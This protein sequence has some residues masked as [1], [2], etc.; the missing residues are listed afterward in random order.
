MSLKR[1]FA[2]EWLKLRRTIAL[3]MV[4]I[5]PA[6]VTL[7]TLFI[8]SQAPFSTLRRSPSADGWGPLVRI[9][10][11]FWALLMLPLYW[12]LQ[13]ALLAS[14]DHTENQ[15]KALFARPVPRWSLYAAKLLMVLL[16]VSTSGVLLVAGIVAEGALLSRLTDEVRFPFPAPAGNMLMQMVQMTALAALPLVLQ[17]WISLRSRSFPVAVASGIVAIVAGFAMLLAAGPYGAWPQ[18]FPWSLPMLVLS[19]QP[20]NLG[21][22]LEISGILASLVIVLSCADF[23]RRDVT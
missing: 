23:C 12:T 20:Y 5:A 18:Y 15:W 21:R 1:T 17:F 9:N 16:M 4:V 11:Q 8:I 6:A 22:V 13:T 2:A 14:L 19:R 3:K 7:L 10:L